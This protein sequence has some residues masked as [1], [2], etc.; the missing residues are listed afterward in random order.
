MREQFEVMMA[1]VL[2]LKKIMEALPEEIWNIFEFSELR[3][4]KQFRRMIGFDGFENE[5]DIGFID[6]KEIWKSVEQLKNVVEEVIAN[7]SSTPATKNNIRS[8]RED[9]RS[10]LI[11]DKYFPLHKEIGN[12]REF[13]NIFTKIIKIL[14]SYHLTELLVKHNIKIPLP[15]KQQNFTNSYKS[16]LHLQI[17]RKNMRNLEWKRAESDTTF[18]QIDSKFF[19]ESSKNVTDEE[20]WIEQKQTNSRI[21][22]RP[23]GSTKICDKNH[24]QF[25]LT[26]HE[27]DYYFHPAWNKIKNI[28]E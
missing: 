16:P 8:R 24:W 20:F 28:K 7:E 22:K 9:F 18:F 5:T 1:P 6:F 12:E 17:R 10:T 26:S 3:E 27:E 14:N 21:I 19:F 4:A 2:I 13:N 15:I 25:Q 23:K 11:D